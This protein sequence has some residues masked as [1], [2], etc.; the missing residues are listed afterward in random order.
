MLLKYL[1]ILSGE[2]SDAVTVCPPK[3]SFWT[4]FGQHLANL[5]NVDRPGLAQI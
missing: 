2:K 3:W 4:D 5:R 1:L